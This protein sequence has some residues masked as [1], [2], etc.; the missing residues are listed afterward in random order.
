MCVW[1]FFLCSALPVFSACEQRYCKQ[2]WM[3][4]CAADIYDS[5]DIIQRLKEAAYLHVLWHWP[6]QAYEG[7]LS[8]KYTP[9]GACPSLQNTV[10]H[11]SMFTA[12]HRGHCMSG[13]MWPRCPLQP[14][15]FYWSSVCVLS[16]GLC[17][18]VLERNVVV[19]VDGARALQGWC[20]CSAQDCPGWHVRTH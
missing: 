8:G 19:R 18:C 7:Y 6:L 15:C 16:V 10:N 17:L 5:I 20:L 13:S 9:K 14:E 4:V 2:A 1:I 11:M 3:S 12:E